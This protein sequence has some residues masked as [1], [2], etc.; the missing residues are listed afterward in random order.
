MRVLAFNEGNLGSHV[1]GQGQLEHA[2]RAG[3]AGTGIE[4]TFTTMAPMGRWANALASRPVP[5]LRERRL[6]LPQLRWHVVQS[7]RAE[8]ALR[9]ALSSTP[10]DVVLLHT[11]AVSLG[12]RRLMTNQP[13]AISMD[14]TI[15]DWA[16]MPAWK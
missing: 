5:L 14:T 15:A 1:M 4:V 13:V 16:A 11:Q 6:D 7:R 3:Q 2:L 12:M 10:A 9:K 8:L